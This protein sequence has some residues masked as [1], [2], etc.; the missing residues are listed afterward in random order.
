MKN[1]PQKVKDDLIAELDKRIV[2]K[3]IE[4]TNAELLKKLID[5]AETINEAIMIAELGT[6]Y[7]RTGFHFDKRLEKMTDTIKYFKKKRKIKFCAG[8]K[9]TYAQ[10][11]HRGQL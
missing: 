2:D 10:A 8:Q 1:E 7:K 6:T 9:R 11:Y 4:K 5:Q 3:I